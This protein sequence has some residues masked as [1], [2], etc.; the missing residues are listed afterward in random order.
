MSNKSDIDKQPDEHDLLK[1]KVDEMMS[2]KGPAPTAED[3]EDPNDKAQPK[4]DV[5]EVAAS[6]NEELTADLSAPAVKE[7]ASSAPEL[8]GKK[9]ANPI[10]QVEPIGEGV[11]PGEEKSAEELQSDEL[12]VNEYDDS[13]TE[14]AVEDITAHESD[15]VL[16]VEDLKREKQNPPEPEEPKSRGWGW[17]LLFVLV[18]AG[19]LAIFAYSGFGLDSLGF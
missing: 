16:A 5:S 2:L 7:A 11:E 19:A 1:K 14:K 8:P 9:L 12:Q 15:L 6:V 17:V 18:V 4:S 10:D 13:E 3:P